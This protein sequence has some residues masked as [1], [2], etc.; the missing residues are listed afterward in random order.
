MS[1]GDC[2]GG[3]CWPWGRGWVAGGGGMSSCCWFPAVLLELRLWLRLRLLELRLLR[4]TARFPLPEAPP[5]VVGG[6]GGGPSALAFA[7][8]FVKR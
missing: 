6:G 8:L 4:V 3:T 2:S 1:L 5:A 7:V